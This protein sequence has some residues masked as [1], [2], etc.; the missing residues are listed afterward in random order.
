MKVFLSGG[1]GFIGG[2]VA[3]QLR[4]RG[5][6][7]RAL[8][9]SAEKGKALEQ[10]GCEVVVGDLSDQAALERGMEGVDAVVHAAAVYEVGIPSSQRPAM[11]ETNVNGTRRVLDAAAAAG[12]KQIVYV[13]TV[14][15]FG[16]TGGKVVDET[17]EHPGEKYASYYERTKTEAHR[18]AKQRI[19]DGAPIV[20][21]QPGGVYGPDD[22]SELGNIIDQTVSGKLKLLMFP[23]AGFTFVHVDD[24]AAG[25]VAA[26]DRG[27]PG[28]SYILGGQL[29]TMR[30]LIETSARVAGVKA[31]TREMPGALIKASIPIGP[32]VG[33]LMGFP[34]NLREL[35][36]SA[37]G[38]TFWATCDKAKSELGYDPRELEQGLRDTFEAEGRA[39]AA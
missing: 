28:Q 34:P 18:L 39:T 35:V 22:H 3:Q 15:A 7:V 25:I 20:I 23:D 36:D 38:V 21:V 2:H 10:I 17:Y 8:A 19:A 9:R 26:L 27:K 6:D 1:T 12:V 24:V 29:G 14:G 32:V 16:D 30:D 37:D 11:Y 5:D 31:P 13:S 33:K 4:D